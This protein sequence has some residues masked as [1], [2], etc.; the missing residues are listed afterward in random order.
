MPIRSY[1]LL[2]ITVVSLVIS[3]GINARRWWVTAEA[4]PPQRLVLPVV[5]GKFVLLP[6]TS[7]IP[8]DHWYWGASPTPRPLRCMGG[9]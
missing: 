6:T 9:Q 2:A 5:G 1:V 7:P 3:A 8:Y 4:P